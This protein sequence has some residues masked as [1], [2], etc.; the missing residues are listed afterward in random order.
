MPNTYTQIHIQ[1]VFAVKRRGNLISKDWKLELY[2][3]M[4][5]I[6]TNQ[7]HKMLQINGVSDHVHI[8]IGQRP[9]Q[10]LSELM[11]MIKR[12]SSAWINRKK[13]SRSR[14]SWQEG[15]GAFSY[16]KFQVPN[17]INYI[18]NQEHHHER[19]HFLDEYRDLL[20]VHGVD[21]DERYIFKPVS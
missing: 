1:L 19:Q 18:K 14:F 2:Q 5:G 20:K 11:Q 4:S 15:Y 6:I 8:L 3:Y 17:V 13:L 10:A 12:D 21:Y 9:T 7:G 16:A